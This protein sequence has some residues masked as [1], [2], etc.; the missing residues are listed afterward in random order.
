MFINIITPCSR[1][2]N[3]HI[4]AKSI[5]IPKEN[6]RWIVVFDLAELPHKDLIPDK[7]EVYTHKDPGSISGNAQRNFAINKVTH[8]YL[9]FNDDDTIIHKDLWTNVKDI[10]KDFI[11]FMQEYTDGNLRLDGKAIAVCHIDSHNYIV[12]HSIVNDTRWVL[13]LIEADGIFAVQ[14]AL[15][16]KSIEYVPKILSTYNTLSSREYDPRDLSLRQ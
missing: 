12:S 8:G 11:T 14:T 2:E 1:P 13:N 5:N 7:C 10:N 4:I 9:Y 16:A 15:K 6:Y 3:L